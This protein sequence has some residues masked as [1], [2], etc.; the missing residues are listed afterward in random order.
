MK[1]ICSMIFIRNSTR[2]RNKTSVILLLK[3]TKSYVKSKKYSYSKVS[4]WISSVQKHTF[5]ICYFQPHPE[6]IK[7]RL[8]LFS[9]KKTSYFI[10]WLRKY[11]QFLSG[12]FFRLISTITFQFTG[13]W[14]VC[15]KF[16]QLMEGNLTFFIMSG[17]LV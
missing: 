13:E 6:Q 14:H 4:H 16:S 2:Q 17:I 7:A 8:N 3:S 1:D 5:L 9:V 11:S 15:Y 12:G 10:N